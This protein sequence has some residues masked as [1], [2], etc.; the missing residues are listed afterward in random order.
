MTSLLDTT[1]VPRNSI[2]KKRL[3]RRP[4]LRETTFLDYAQTTALHL[5]NGLAI[6][7]REEWMRFWTENPVYKR[8]GGQWPIGWALEIDG[9]L[10][11][12]IGNIPLAYQFKGRE[13]CVAA[14]CSWAVD[15]HYRPYSMLLLDR[16]MRQKDVDLVISTTVSSSAEPVFTFLQSS[17]MRV[18]TWNKS[19]FWITN[20][21]G[22]S[23]IAL[24]KTSIPFAT[25]LAY[26]LSAVLYCRDRFTEA[27]LR[28]HGSATE[29]ELCSEF[30]G[31]FDEFWE[32][33]N[34]QNDSVL[35][36]SRTRET[37]AW[38]FHD[39]LSRGKAWILAAS[40]GSGLVAYAIFDRQ[41]NSALGL[42]RVRLVDFQ[43]LKGSEEILRSA[44]SWMLHRCRQERIHI[45][46]VTG[47]WLDRPGLPRVRPPCHRTLPSWAYYYR[48]NNTDL[49]ETLR[50]PG[51]WAPS[52][53][54]GDASL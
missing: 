4:K 19:G 25:L 14:A 38:H 24:R 52:S 13:L 46:E 2:R 11:G 9:E 39:A 45:L 7:S 17:K 8:R 33:L 23:R 21:P 20:Y 27:G 10:V 16:L 32:E 28:V 12:S 47:G 42:K 34:H 15:G 43:A 49:V 26:P 35:L 50:D 40:K 3:Q 37:L 51:V 1:S 44:L 22:F 54:D 18:G 5:R 41:D 36:A 6:R 29:L 48:A 31:R 53:F 30:D